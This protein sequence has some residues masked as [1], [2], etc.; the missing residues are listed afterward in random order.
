MNATRITPDFV[1]GFVKTCM[2]N[3]LG[4]DATDQLFRQHALNAFIAT[5]G[6]YNGFSTKLAAY[7]GTM[8]RAK[9]A[10]YM[11]PEVLAK[12]AEYRVRFGDDALSEQLRFELNLPE[13]SWDNVEPEL[14]KVASALNNSMSYYAQ[15]P[16]NQKVLIAALAGGGI[17]GLSRLVHPSVDDQLM[18]R[19][20]V[21][22]TVRGI[23]RGGALGTGAAV[24]SEVGEIAGAEAGGASGVLP[25]MVAGGIGGGLLTNK[26]T[27]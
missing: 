20:R 13:P 25:G 3:G 7:D 16:M 12:V 19:G 22:R 24:G 5:P 17:S 14:R 26:F 10:K 18:D 4:V 2:D 11:T 27:R 1:E 6:I 8:S 23:A 21:N 9:M 15:L